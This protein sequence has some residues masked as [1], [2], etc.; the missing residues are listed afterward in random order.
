MGSLSVHGIPTPDHPRYG[1]YQG[2]AKVEPKTVQGLLRHSYR[3]SKQHT[4]W[5]KR[6]QRL[7]QCDTHTIL[8]EIFS[9]D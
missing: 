4:H 8:S 5:H 7:K 9:H 3:T 2:W 1:Q 6:D